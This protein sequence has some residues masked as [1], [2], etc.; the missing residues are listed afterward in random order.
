MSVKERI[1]KLTFF[2]IM[3]AIEAVFCFTILGSIPIGP[4]V[5]TLAMLPVIITSLVLGPIY[6]SVMGFIAGS[7]SFIY[8]SF[9]QPAYPTAFVFSPI[10]NGGNFWSLV[11]C[12]VPRTL[13]GLFPAL[14]YEGLNKVNHKLDKLWLILASIIGSLTNTI[15]VLG[16]MGIFFGSSFGDV[17]T[18][19]TLIGTTILTNGLIEAAVSAL[20]CTLAVFAIQQIKFTTEN[21]EASKNNNQVVTEETKT[22][23]Q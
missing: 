21:K 10:A 1:S 8:W 5:A 4:F 15:L 6:G 11:I 22:V 12:F 19:L 17:K 16:G 9:I 2:A 23:K 3:L 13:T 18:V 14:F 20:V 7:F